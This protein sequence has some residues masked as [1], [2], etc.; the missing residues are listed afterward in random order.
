MAAQVAKPLSSLE[1]LK[2]EL[3]DEKAHP[4]SL[5]YVAWRVPSVYVGLAGPQCI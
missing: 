5:V 1:K 3:E 2:A 4:S